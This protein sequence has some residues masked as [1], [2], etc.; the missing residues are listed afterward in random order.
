MSM[1][2]SAVLLDCLRIALNVVGAFA[3]GWAAFMV[4]V[5][6]LWKRFKVL[7][8]ALLLRFCHLL[9]SPL[10]MF[11]LYVCGARLFLMLLCW[12]PHQGFNSWVA[13]LLAIPYGAFLYIA[14]N[15]KGLGIPLGCRL[16]LT[17]E[18]SPIHADISPPP[19]VLCF[20]VDGD[21]R[22][23]REA[24]TK[25]IVEAINAT[26]ACGA[27]YDFILKS[28]FFASRDES[29]NAGIPTIRRYMRLIGNTAFICIGFHSLAFIG[30]FLFPSI[31]ALWW[32][33]G[34][35][36]VMLPAVLLIALWLRSAV[37]LMRTITPEGTSWPEETSAKQLRKA[38][39]RNAPGYDCTF[40]SRRPLSK[41]HFVGLSMAGLK[42]RNSCGGAEAG[43]RLV[44]RPAQCQD[45]PLS[46]I[47]GS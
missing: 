18:P 2:I 1:D 23:K 15:G 14:M 33:I 42:V 37:E 31:P 4:V 12:G 35:V 3:L 46:K 30:Y 22:S 43:L 24:I 9:A 6:A 16:K 5:P 20:H 38:L 10:V 45:S 47:S 25:R 34:I 11:L 13:L 19:L 40:I 27:D 39:L 21:F 17:I 36:I 7:P 26:H 8:N 44:R 29:K 32:L 28:W 41:R